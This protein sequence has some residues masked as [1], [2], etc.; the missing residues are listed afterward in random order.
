MFNNFVIFNIFKFFIVKIKIYDSE[1]LS[2][3]NLYEFFILFYRKFWNIE[4]LCLR[5]VYNF[6]WFVY[7]YLVC[8]KLLFCKKNETCYM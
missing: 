7:V 8:C 6:L 1:L 2:I 5:F 4:G 3:L